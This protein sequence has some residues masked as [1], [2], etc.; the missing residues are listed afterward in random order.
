[1]SLFGVSVAIVVVVWYGREGHG[2]GWHC[3]GGTVI[4]VGGVVWLS[5]GIGGGGG[6]FRC[7]VEVVVVVVLV[8]L[9]SSRCGGSLGIQ[10]LCG[11]GCAHKSPVIIVSK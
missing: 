10:Q 8:A 2:G 6:L 4:I 5:Y 11:C 1:M 7:V 3:V 9:S